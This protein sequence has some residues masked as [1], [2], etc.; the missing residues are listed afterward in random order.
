V[1]FLYAV[2]GVKKNYSAH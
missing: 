2:S 1:L